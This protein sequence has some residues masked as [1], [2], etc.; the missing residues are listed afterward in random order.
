MGQ[1]NSEADIAAVIDVLRT[2]YDG[3]IEGDPAKLGRAFHPR[4][5]HAS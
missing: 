1:R 2:Y 4:A 3:M 5:H